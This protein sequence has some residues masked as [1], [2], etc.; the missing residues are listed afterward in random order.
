MSNRL[1]TDIQDRSVAVGASGR[2]QVV[3]VRL[4]VWPA[5]ALE[6]IPC[7]ELLVAMCA[8]EVLRMPCLA[9]RGDDLHITLSCRHC[10]GDTSTALNKD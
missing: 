10:F 1:G 2:E 4:A 7:T 3:I 9:Q 5:V 8:G 6:E